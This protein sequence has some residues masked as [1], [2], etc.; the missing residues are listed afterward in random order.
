MSF[1]ATVQLAVVLFAIYLGY[2]QYSGTNR[3]FAFIKGLT[4][5]FAALAITALIRLLVDAFRL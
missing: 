4:Y 2:Q 5:G 3:L 1:I